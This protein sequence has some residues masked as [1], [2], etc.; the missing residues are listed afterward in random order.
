[1]TSSIIAAPVGFVFLGAAGDGACMAVHGC[2]LLAGST[3]VLVQF[4]L[5]SLAAVT[6]A[7]TAAALWSEV[8]VANYVTNCFAVV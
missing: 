8:S 1:M 7:V 2:V 3:D 6:A 4:S 5:S